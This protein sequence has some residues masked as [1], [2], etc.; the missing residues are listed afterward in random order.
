[1]SKYTK[2]PWVVATSNNNLLRILA[3][4]ELIA[5]ITL[6]ANPLRRVENAYLI[7]AAPEMLD[8][9]HAADRLMLLRDELSTN[10]ARV[11]AR[12]GT[13]ES[14]QVSRVRA[15]EIQGEI[16]QIRRTIRAAIAK[17]AGRS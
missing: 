7:A 17:A 9:L 11:N 14:I 8:A 4:E 2:G 3:G 16:T 10:L 1:M 13:V 5:S 15:E 12:Q 6:N